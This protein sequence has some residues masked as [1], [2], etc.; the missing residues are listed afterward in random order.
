MYVRTVPW[1]QLTCPPPLKDLHLFSR[2]DKFLAKLLVLS[3][4]LSCIRQ[5]FGKKAQSFKLS[6]AAFAPCWTH[7]VACILPPLTA[8]PP[9]KKKRDAGEWRSGENSFPSGGRQRSVKT[10]P[11]PV[12]FELYENTLVSLYICSDPSHAKFL[13]KVYPGK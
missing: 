1:D 3:T 2:P 9:K 4:K 12:E 6:R 10:F 7:E 5:L 8:P 11:F 13:G